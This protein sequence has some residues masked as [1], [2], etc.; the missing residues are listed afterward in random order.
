MTSPT[1]VSSATTDNSARSGTTFALN[2]PAADSSGGADDVLLA[3]LSSEYGT[4]GAFAPGGSWSVLYDIQVFASGLDN[5]I[6]ALCCYK[7]A[8]GSEGAT[9]NITVQNDSCYATCYR[10]SGAADPATKPPEYVFQATGSDTSPH[11][12]PL[13]PS[14]KAIED[15]MAFRAHHATRN[16]G[17]SYPLSDH[18]LQSGGDCLVG[19]C[20]QAHTGFAFDDPGFFGGFTTFWSAG[21]SRV[22]VYPSTSF[23]HPF[24]NFPHIE[25][26]N[27][28]DDGD[29]TGSRLSLQLPAGIS[30]GDILLT[31]LTQK[32]PTSSSSSSNDGVFWPAGWEERYEFEHVGGTFYG[33]CATKVAD[34]TEG[35]SVLMD[36]FA[37]AELSAI[38][39][40]ISN[41][42][43][44][45]FQFR[46][47]EKS[48][49][50]DFLRWKQMAPLGA[51]DSYRYFK[52]THEPRIGRITSRD[53]SYS[54]YGRID[55]TGG[56]VATRFADYAV[57]APSET[58]DAISQDQSGDYMSAIIALQG[59]VVSAGDIRVSQVAAQLLYK[60]FVGVRITQ[61]AAQVLVSS[62]P[63]VRHTCQVWK[64]TRTDG[65]VFRFTTH[66]SAVTFHGETYS[67]CDSLKAS[68]AES[69]VL[70]AVGGGDIEIQ[71]LI[72]ADS[73]TESDLANGSF[74]GADLEVWTIP[75]DDPT[76]A[77]HSP[78][79]IIKAI[80]GA[81]TQGPNAY[82][83]EAQCISA[84]MAQTPLLSIAS[85]ACRFEPGDGKCP[86]NTAALTFSGN[87]ITAVTR[88]AYNRSSYR[89]FYH[90]AS[91][92]G[93]SEQLTS[94]YNYGLLTWTVGNNAGL[95]SEIKS[96]DSDGLV[97]LWEQ[98]PNEIAVSD[99]FTVRP[100]CNKTLS[101]HTGK[102]GLDADS[103]GGFP[104][105]PGLDAI[106]RVNN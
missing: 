16:F 47:E 15:F 78:K 92:S 59:D 61:V 55:S 54:S 12:N 83:A 99:Q 31:V 73:I 87:V 84:K 85:S 48:S 30:A 29:L 71:G 19:S 25:S 21:T 42:V 3:F 77:S 91:S 10:I 40:R 69:A 28:T 36:V 86:V 106:L 7:K 24:D 62:V 18:Q 101:D 82:E 20:C 88:N 41:A 23:A 63:C 37:G 103:F 17:L 14:N 94:Y 68:A 22:L 98:M 53:A 26:V 11:C 96:V 4:A 57:S 51:T 38:T 56:Q 44:E 66:D 45:S 6:T 105:I 81:T 49:S 8:T 75:W 93:S 79:R 60:E 64:I 5:P 72:S 97:T 67:P 33:A 13:L 58:P 1:I 65:E 70:N 90:A 46:R 104:D 89:Q 43:P 2:I 80:L 9:E 34:G 76:L 35:S 100:G 52:V 74:D 39:Y 32:A 50:F 102:F 95:S 27:Y